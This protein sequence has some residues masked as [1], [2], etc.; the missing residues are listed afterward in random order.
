MIALA[1]SERL[2]RTADSVVG[3]RLVDLAQLW[4]LHCV[5]ALQ[6]RFARVPGGDDPLRGYVSRDETGPTVVVA[7]A[8]KTVKFD[9]AAGPK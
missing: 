9:P 7:C 6:V 1:G 4:R 2:D 5:D 8:G 3:L